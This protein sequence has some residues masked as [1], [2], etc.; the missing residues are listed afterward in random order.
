MSH[1]IAVGFDFDHTLGVDNRLERTTALDLLAGY[2]RGRGLTYDVA[3][4]DDAIDGV[5]HSYRQGEQSVEGAIAGFFERFAP[6]GKTSDVL[7]EAGN[8]RDAVLE[9]AER[10][11]EPLPGAREMLAALD[12]MNVPYAIVTNGWSPLQ[13][14][15]A[16]LLG[17]RGPVFV[18]ERIGVRKPARE[19]FAAL[20][21]AFDLPLE[22]IWYVGD[23]P[24]SDC[25]GA[26]AAGLTAVW[27][28]WENASYP[29]ELP[30]PAHTIHALAE[31]PALLVER[32]SEATPG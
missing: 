18:S 3:A 9:R 20:E 1:S 8:F 7:D 16:R 28:D 5:L 32:L 19:A 24:H 4:A 30:P 2:A 10:H 26:S 15:K 13:E 27:Y 29:A 21:G 6:G 12:A 22:R 23:D 17:F 11:I 31:L 14:E 25:A